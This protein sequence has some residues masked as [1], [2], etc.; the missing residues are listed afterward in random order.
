MAAY[1]R[2][3]E[4]G[5]TV[6][7]FEIDPVMQRIATDPALFSY[8]RDCRSVVNIVLGDAR[9]RIAEAAAASLDCLVLDAFTSD[10]I[11]VHLLTKE[12]VE[13]YFTKLSPGGVLA[14]HISSRYLDLGPPL[15][16]IARDLGLVAYQ[17]VD[18]DSEGFDKEEGR[19]S[20]TWLVMARAPGMLAGL[21]ADPRWTA[22]TVHS[23]VRAW[24]DDY[25][26]VLGVFRWTDR[27]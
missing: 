14:F 5:G 16:A 25:S 26:N 19:T 23:G 2:P 20:S 17:R 27:R 12:A 21:A 15:G 22:Y 24:T 6:T 11:P 3:R 13:L 9:L 8:V 10:A 18:N 4:Q 1:G 7:F